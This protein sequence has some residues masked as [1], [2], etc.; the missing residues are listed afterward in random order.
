MRPTAKQLAMRDPAMAALMGAHGEG[1]DFGGDE[2]DAGF[3]FGYE[4]G[5]DTSVPATAMM[6]GQTPA[7]P[8][9]AV[10]AQL[11]QKHL[12]DSHATNQRT[13]LL[14]PNG[15]SN[16]KVERYAFYLNTSVV[17][18]T[19]GAIS[20]SNQP[21]TTI[22]PQRVTCNAPCVGFA[23][24]DNIKVANVSVLVGGSADA[25]EYNPNSVGASLDMPTLS[26]ANRASF[27]GEYSG[28]VPPGYNAASS[29]NFI[30]GLKGPATIAGG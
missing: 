1:S 29:F 21:D 26:P 5:I 27:S 18:G 8:P 3:E 23:S 13:R 9:P 14:E 17:L 28:L 22:R 20:A 24:L 10:A 15:G 16:V 19:A 6:T 12:A 4:F 30:V 25:F 2:L 11:W 7:Q